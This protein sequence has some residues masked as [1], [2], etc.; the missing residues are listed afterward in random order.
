[1]AICY[2]PALFRDKP[3]G[4]PAS[5]KMVHYCMMEDERQNKY[6]TWYNFYTILNL[7]IWL[8][9][10]YCTATLELWLKDI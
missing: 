10:I 8:W 9:G 7:H 4:A 2:N 3:L 1:M 5:V 6:W